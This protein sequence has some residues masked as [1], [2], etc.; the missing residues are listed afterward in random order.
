MDERISELTRAWAATR[1]PAL[2]EALDV[3][4]KRAGA[5]S[6]DRRA[7]YL[8]LLR[9]VAAHANGRVEVVVNGMRVAQASYAVRPDGRGVDLVGFFTLDPYDEM[10]IVLRE[11]A[12]PDNVRITVVPETRTLGE[13][14]GGTP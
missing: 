12:N 1:D 9:A 5:I 14:R 8:R 13:L 4:C 2:A 10:L 6:P 3:A 7:A 11:P